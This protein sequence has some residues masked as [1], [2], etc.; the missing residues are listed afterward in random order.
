MQIYTAAITPAG[1]R[2][3]DW[4]H[5]SIELFCAFD[6]S[7]HAFGFNEGKN[8]DIARSLSGDRRDTVKRIAALED[9]EI[10]RRQG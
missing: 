7:D 2:I 4:Q 9:L 6:A 8:P 1:I 5:T 3:M 10:S